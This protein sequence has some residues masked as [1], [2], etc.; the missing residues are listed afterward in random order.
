MLLHRLTRGRT[1]SSSAS[2]LPARRFIEGASTR[3]PLPCNFLPMLSDLT[4]RHHRTAS[5]CKCQHAAPCSMPTT[6]RSSPTAALVCRSSSSSATRRRLPLI[7]VQFNL[8]KVG[9]HRPQFDAPQGSCHPGQTPRQ[10]VNTDLF[11]NV[12]EDAQQASTTPVDYNTDLFDHCYASSPLDRTSGSSCCSD[13]T[14]VLDA[15][16]SVRR[17]PHATQRQER[18]APSHMLYNQTSADFGTFEPMARHVPSACR[19]ASTPYRRHA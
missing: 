19:G 5:N 4:D 10:F 9:S 15:A 12:I 1:K 8:E 17:V 7:E 13:M 18:R 2:P 14:A 3:G 16:Q 11:L 6:I